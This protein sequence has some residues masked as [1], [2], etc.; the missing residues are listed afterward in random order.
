MDRTNPD[1]R[2]AIVTALSQE[3]NRIQDRIETAMFERLPTPEDAANRVATLTLKQFQVGDDLSA[4]IGH[5]D[6]DNV[7]DYERFQHLT[8]MDGYS[9]SIEQ[10]H[11]WRREA[12]AEE[13]S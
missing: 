13:A 3:Y 10:A 8:G 9:L 1:F 5:C 7:A 4:L 11:R 6:E 12:G 2:H